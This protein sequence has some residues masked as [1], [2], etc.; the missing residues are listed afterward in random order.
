MPA[1]ARARPERS[2]GSVGELPSGALRVAVY[3]GF[4]PLTGKRHYLREGR[5]VAKSNERTTGAGAN[6]RLRP[7]G[8]CA[9]R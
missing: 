7:V 6:A 2:R 5:G 1:S 4:D 3:A 8:V 9:C